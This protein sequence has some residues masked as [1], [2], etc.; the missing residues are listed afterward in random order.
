[1]FIAECWMLSCWFLHMLLSCF[2][3][4]F[5][6]LY[7]FYKGGDILKRRRNLII[8]VCLID[9]INYLLCYLIIWFIHVHSLK[10]LIIVVW[11]LFMTF[12]N[13]DF[14][15]DDTM[16]QYNINYYIFACIVI[17]YSFTCDNSFFMSDYNIHARNLIGLR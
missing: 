4:W 9:H 10:F 14:W 13:H 12:D 17:S 1:M 7:L 3:F 6:S 8:L 15:Y 11:L 2:C 16:L 5:S